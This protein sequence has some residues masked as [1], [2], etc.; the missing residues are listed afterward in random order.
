VFVTLVLQFA[1]SLPVVRRVY[2]SMIK[3]THKPARPEIVVLAKA[4]NS[5]LVS[6]LAHP[7][8]QVNLPTPLRSMIFNVMLSMSDAPADSTGWRKFADSTDDTKADMG[9]IARIM[10]ENVKIDSFLVTKVR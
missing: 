1:A 10:L 5:A 8:Y 9:E 7:G 4:S 3:Y 2:L 6:F